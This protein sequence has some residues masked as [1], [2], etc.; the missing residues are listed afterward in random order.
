M[1]SQTAPMLCDCYAILTG[2]GV[3]AAHVHIDDISGLNDHFFGGAWCI[4]GWITKT[5]F[6]FS[7]AAWM[8]SRCNPC[9]HCDCIS[10]QRASG[11]VSLTQRSH[12][13]E[14][15]MLRGSSF[16]IVD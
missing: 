10:M 8:Q 11:H 2:A 13:D 3:C 14:I 6:L 16:S 1:T 12:Q 9:I 15:S 4:A 5:L 7:K